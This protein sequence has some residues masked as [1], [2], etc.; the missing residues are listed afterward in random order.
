MFR[1]I[2]AFLLAVGCVFALTAC[3][4]DYRRPRNDDGDIDASYIMV[5]ESTR[6]DMETF[7][8]YVAF[9]VFGV[10]ATYDEDVW[11]M[12]EGGMF[13]AV[14]ERALNVLIEAQTIRFNAAR[15]GV[16]LTES[17]LE[18]ART[19]A[20]EQQAEFYTEFG[21]SIPL[22]ALLMIIEDGMLMQKIFDSI[23]DDVEG[24]EQFEREFEQS[25]EILGGLLL[26]IYTHFVV[27]EDF[28]DAV[29]AQERLRAGEDA[30]TVIQELSVLYPEIPFG[31]FGLLDLPLPAE[32]LILIL[33]F[34]ENDVSE[35]IEVDGLYFVVHVD[36]IIGFD[37]DEVRAAFKVLYVENLVSRNLTMWLE[38]ANF[39]I[40]M[41]AF[42]SLVLADV[43]GLF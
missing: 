25:I 23:Y 8:Y 37:Y 10:D 27:T 3:V 18:E 29:Y 32:E 15:L 42:E 22:N 34:E 14:K 39:T 28:D 7:K 26:T 35:I 21:I 43:H 11:E 40:N 41:A 24:E 16:S 20:K 5:F 17:E 30:Q 9:Q 4:E 31:R 12:F 38:I 36:E 2:L 6:V 13:G 33:E 19:R 1:K